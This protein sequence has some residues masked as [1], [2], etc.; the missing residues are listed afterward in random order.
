MK[1]EDVGSYG[2]AGNVLFVN[3][4]DEVILFDTSINGTWKVDVYDVALAAVIALIGTGGM[5]GENKADTVAMRKFMKKMRPML[6]KLKFKV[7]GCITAGTITVSLNSFNLTALLNAISR[8]DVDAFHTAYLITAA[9]INVA[10]ILAALNTAGFLPANVLSLKT[11]HD[12][13]WGLNTTKI[14]LKGNISDLSLANQDIINNA[15]GIFNR[16]LASLKGMFESLDDATNAGKCTQKAVLDSVRPTIAPKVRN[17]N[18]VKNGSFVYQTDLAKR[19]VMKLTVTS[20]SKKSLYILN[21]AY[22]TGP[23]T[24][25]F[26]LK[27]GVEND[28]KTKD[29]PGTGKYVIIY[30]P[31]T[32]DD[33]VVGCLIV[34]G[35]S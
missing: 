19:D 15:I 30:N 22:K 16:V 9:Q 26:E 33:G 21:S 4:Y 5:K 8:N 13:A 11:N 35:A 28:L 23:F 31:D 14:T 7:E 27:H 34:K 6:K 25:G 18:A 29:I 20:K 17:R 32:T 1:I 24:G 3:N 12:G 2:T 10:G